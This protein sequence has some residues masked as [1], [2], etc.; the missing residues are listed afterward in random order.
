[1]MSP[2]DEL[3]LLLARGQLSPEAQERALGLL[4]CPL[5]WDFLLERAR[6]HQ[7]VPLLYRSLRALDFQGV[8][9]AARAQLRAAFQMNALRNAFLAGELARVLQLLNDSGVPVIPLKG[10]TLAESLYG[11]SAFRVCS[12][13]DILVPPSEAL[14]A[15]RLILAH[16]YTSPFTED[17]F[18]NH[19]LRTIG[20]CPLF[21]AK[22]AFSYP[23]EVHWT[24]LRHS[25]KDDQAM[26]DLWFRARPKDF[27]GVRAYSLTPDWE[28]LYLAWHAAYHK[29]HTLKWLA[30]IHELCV[31]A[32]IDWQQVREKAERFELDSIV[33]YTLTACS[34]LF[35]TPAPANFLSR[36][37]PAGVHLF[38]TS[39][40]PSE[41]WKAQL[42][43]PR[44]LKRPSERLRC[45]AEMF[46]VPRLADYTFFPLPP[47]LSFLYYFLR[48]LRLTGKWS[49]LLLS[50]GFR[51]LRRR[52]HF[53]PE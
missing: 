37:L 6:E 38:P 34:S 51:G 23:L 45:M 36:A 31:S 32:H 29:W 26:Q 49:W 27:F 7:V 33:G 3:C 11:D 2:E 1:M 20:E 48:P 43:Y 13:I 12:D 15:R 8:P 24:L 14:R 53:S 9:D 30:D 28:F 21:P 18:V 52:L 19:Q 39:L 4:E 40:A 10:V 50:A 44:L 5:R 46:F 47:S 35:G 16:G 22:Q 17:F 42:F 41:V 25:R